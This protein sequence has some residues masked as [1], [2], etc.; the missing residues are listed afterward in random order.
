MTDI[1]K[2][3]YL[4]AY[5]TADPPSGRLP[6]R[7]GIVT[8][9]NSDGEPQPEEVNWKRDR[10]LRQVLIDAG[11]KHFRVTGGSRDASHREP[12]FGILAD[13]LDAIRAISKRFAQAAFF[14]VE[15]GVVFAVNTEGT[16]RHRVDLWIHRQM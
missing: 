10:E 11:L 6:N 3:D 12:G 9:F 15:D 14:W 13:S 4:Q 1:P 5:F 8:A 2:P 7:F 16:T